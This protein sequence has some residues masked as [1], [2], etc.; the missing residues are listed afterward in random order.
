MH[1]A[2]D[3]CGDILLVVRETVVAAPAAWKRRLGQWVWLVEEDLRRGVVLRLGWPPAVYAEL[4]LSDVSEVREL[5]HSSAVTLRTRFRLAHDY[6]LP[7][8]VNPLYGTIIEHR[9]RAD[10]FDGTAYTR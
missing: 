5:C 6:P 4:C 7:R 1:D 8:T 9:N 3:E 2:L 10:K